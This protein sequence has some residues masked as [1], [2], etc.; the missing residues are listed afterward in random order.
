M[1][2][3]GYFSILMVDHNVMRLYVSMH[4]SLA[5]A[6]IQALEQL[7]DVVSNIDVVELGVKAPEIGI[8]DVLEYKGRC[9][10]L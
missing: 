4:D 9:F 1:L 2:E 5:M 3:G 7:V 8:I 6:V 10:A